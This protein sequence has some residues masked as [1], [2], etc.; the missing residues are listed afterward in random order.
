ML[1]RRR[2]GVFEPEEQFL[3][4]FRG[5]IA[6]RVVEREKTC[7]ASENW[8][9]ARRAL[10]TVVAFPKAGLGVRDRL[11]HLEDA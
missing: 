7:P 6:A 4:V 1:R 5:K 2:I 3:R 8:R 10:P 11:E 9:W